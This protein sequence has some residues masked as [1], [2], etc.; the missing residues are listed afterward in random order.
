MRRV[1]AELHKVRSREIEDKIAA[2]NPRVPL[3][4]GDFTNWKPK[5][6]NDVIDYCEKIIEQYDEDFI[7]SRMH[8]DKV[9]SYR[10]NER[11]TFT[12]QESAIF[13]KYTC[14]FYENHVPQNWKQIL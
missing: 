12:D 2:D 13:K 1:M 10:K 4:M 8:L 7:I 5:P 11:E 3:I 9:L 6:M 14:D